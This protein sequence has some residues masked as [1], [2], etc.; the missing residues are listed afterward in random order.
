M[1]VRAKFFVLNALKSP[2]QTVVRLGAVC[3]GEDNK[4]WAAATPNAEVSMTIL[5][6]VAAEFF[7]PGREVYVDFSYAPQGKEG[8]NG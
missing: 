8:M 1:S 7:E 5:N 6:D 4:E 3:R 2:H